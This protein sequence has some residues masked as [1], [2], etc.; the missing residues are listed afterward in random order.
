M[1]RYL[2]VEEI[3]RIHR[4]LVEDFGGLEGVRDANALESACARPQIGYYSDIIEEAA[5]LFESLSQNHPFLDGNKRTAITSVAMFLEYN[6]YELWVD[7]LTSY[8]WLIERY[9]SGTMKKAAIE[10]WLR[11]HVTKI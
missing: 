5:A 6:G 3:L 10:T 8:Q 4:T 7:S 1:T 11:E 9:E 2:T